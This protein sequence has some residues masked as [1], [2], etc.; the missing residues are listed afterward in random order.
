MPID[1]GH[2]EL[3]GR[4]VLLRPLVREDASAL[5]RA[6]SESQATYDM[7]NVPMGLAA[8]E[9]YIDK[10]LQ[11]RDAGE[12]Y[13][14]AIV[15]RDRVVG[16][17]SY[18]DFQ[19]WDWPQESQS[20]LQRHDRPDVTEIGYTWLAAS[21]QRTRCNTESK[22]LLMEHAFE[23]WQVHRVFLRTDERNVRSR[24]AI[25]RLGCQLEGIR[26]ADMP[27]RDSTVR[28]SAYY[29]MLASEWPVAKQSLQKRL[30]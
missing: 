25:E 7:S 17:T 4:E 10:A 2:I 9:R 29:S 21:A 16:S 22:F 30:E 23:V 14:F 1:L 27:G 13:P 5:D 28:N 19:P 11:M 26:R 3:R 20:Q 12:R 18:Y 8:C 15:W 6:T 24:R